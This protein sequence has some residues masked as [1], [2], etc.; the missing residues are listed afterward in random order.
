M[1]FVDALQT[2]ENTQYLTSRKQGS[3][4][5]VQELFSGLVEEITED[6]IEKVR[7]GY[8]G[9]SIQTGKD[10]YTE[11]EWDRIIRNFD[12]M[13]K[14]MKVFSDAADTIQENGN[15]IPDEEDAEES[16]D[17]RTEITK[18][19]SGYN[20]IEVEVLMAEYTVTTYQSP[21]GQETSVYYTYYSYHGIYC[22]KEGAEGFE[23]E[24]TY[25]NEEQY[26]KVS[27]FMEHFKGQDNLLFASQK[28]FW[29]DFLD[30]KI[31]IDQFVGFWQDNMMQRMWE[32]QQDLYELWM[33]EWIENTDKNQ[34]KVI[35]EEA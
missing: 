27:E 29:Q 25:E 20:R 31:D 18:A 35:I 13:Q 24:L 2:G 6:T 21:N 26:E 19:L 17:N 14:N 32:W 30:G 15:M 22:K 5:S 7:S 23:W 1:G 12:R 8:D 16:V 3:K 33:E 9:P 4:G 34:E 11:K 10:A 28:D